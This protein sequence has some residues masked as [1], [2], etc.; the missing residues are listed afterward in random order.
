MG[1]VKPPKP[2]DQ[3]AADAFISGAPDAVG[4]EAR[5]GV[6]KGKRVQISHTITDDLLARVDEMAQ[7]QAMSRAGLINLAISQL[8]ERGA[9]IDGNPRKRDAE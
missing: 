1:I 8:L 2:V 7:A 4:A 6:R 5:K 9:V 3:K